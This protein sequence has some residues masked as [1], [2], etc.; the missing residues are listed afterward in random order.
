[1]LSYNLKLIKAL[2]FSFNDKRNYLLRF[3]QLR[4]LAQL[5]SFDLK[6]NDIMDSIANLIREEKDIFYLRG[7]QK[8]QIKIVTNLLSQTDFG[9]EKIAN[10]ANVTVDFVKNVRD[11]LSNIK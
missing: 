2:A 7:Q 8:E 10:I 6:L 1:M 3:N 5:R 11:K 9:L 4:V